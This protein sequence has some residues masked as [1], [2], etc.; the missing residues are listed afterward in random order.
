[1][2]SNNIDIVNDALSQLKLFKDKMVTSMF[3]SISLQLEY[4][5]K[6]LNEENEGER[7]DEIMFRT[8]VAREIECNFPDLADKLYNALEVVDS[9][10]GMKRT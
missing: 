2:K 9:L 1:M 10:K 6:H 3:D 4:V 8:Y 7:L 5:V